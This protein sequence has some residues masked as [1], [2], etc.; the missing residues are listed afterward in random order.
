[1]L[2]ACA[3][4]LARDSD[5]YIESCIRILSP[6]VK[7]IRV[8]VDLRTE[9]NTLPL[10]FRLSYEIS[11]LEIR[12][13]PVQN[14]LVDLVVARNDLLRAPEPWG[15]IVD[16]DE[17]HHEI[18]KYEFTDAPAYAFQCWAVWNE[19]H[20]HRSSSKSIIGRV[21]RNSQNVH[22]RGLFGKEVLY[23]GNTPVFSNAQVLPYRY[24]HF[25]HLKKDHWRTELNQ[26]RVADGKY[27]VQMP[28]SII[29]KVR[30]IH[31]R[32]PN[33]PRYRV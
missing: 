17:F 21:F 30:E 19:T 9:D 27:L 23:N 18:E 4:M 22:W 6:H 15:F 29:T 24:I 13:V 31:A 11:N 14:P 20:A 26:E 10:L 12:V 16:S 8:A 32:M 1:M 33:V 25:T 3:M 7:R 2:D 28:S 5:D